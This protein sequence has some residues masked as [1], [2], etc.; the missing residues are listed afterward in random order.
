[1][2]ADSKL[3]VSCF[4]YVGEM[5][6]VDEIEDFNKRLMPELEK[7][8]RVFIMGTS[9]KGQYAIR[10]CFINHR[11]TKQTTSYL[12]EVIREVAHQLEKQ[13]QVLYK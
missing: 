8:G 6:D 13:T 1:M 5:T 2:V 4:R 9:L 7:D 3:A 11:K 10:A 12:L